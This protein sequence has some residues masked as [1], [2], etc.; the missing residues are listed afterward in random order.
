MCANVLPAW[1][2]FELEACEYLNNEIVNSTIEFRQTG[3]KNSLTS[4]IKVFKNNINLFSIEAK[5]SPSQSGQFVILE[6]NGVYFLSD[7]GRFSNKYTQAIIDH[8]NANNNEYSPQGQKATNIKIDENLM[9]DWVIEHYKNKD[10]HFV[11]TSTE[12]GG[13]K[14][15]F[16]IEDIKK[17]FH[18]TA[19]VRRKR[20][21]TRSVPRSKME[22]CVQELHAHARNLGLTV[23]DFKKGDKPFVA[24]SENLEIDKKGRYF[25]KQ[26]YLSPED[27]GY[28]V[29][30]RAST[31]NINV[32]FS[33]HYKGPKSNFGKEEL[34]N[35]INKF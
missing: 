13:Y 12:L 6:D 5:L 2:E 30:V 15:I 18:V 34:E 9:V 20:S 11:I 27:G 3:G 22:D 16:P 24:F 21:G 10:S 1:E 19:V 23:T 32:I 8:L 7:A 25:G 17:Y 33:L 31:N 29:K 26:Y 4:D 14:A 28:N 35:F